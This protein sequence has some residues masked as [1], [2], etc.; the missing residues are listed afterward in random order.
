MVNALKNLR[1]GSQEIAPRSIPGFD[2]IAPMALEPRFMFDAAGAATAADSAEQ[3]QADAEAEQATQQ[4]SDT[5]SSNS[6]SSQSEDAATQPNVPASGSEFDVLRTVDAAQNGG[7]KEVVFIDGSLTG[8][9]DL[10]ADIGD[11]VEIVV[12]DGNADG[13][14]Q[15]VAWAAQNADFDALHIISHGAEGVVYLGNMTLNSETVIARADDLAAIGASLTESGDILLYGCRVAGGDGKAFADAL[16]L[17]TGA[18]IAAS[19]DDTGASNLGG[20]W[21]LE[22]ATGALEGMAYSS[23]YEH[24]LATDN[25]DSATASGTTV[26]SSVDG[27]GYTIAT[28]SG[29][30]WFEF[31]G[32]TV[33]YTSGGSGTVPFIG[34]HFWGQATGDGTSYTFNFNSPVNITSIGMLS[35]ST[36][37]GATYVFSDTTSGSSN[38]NVNVAF[39]SLDGVTMTM[40]GGYHATNVSLGWTAVSS[41]TVTLTGGDGNMRLA[42]DDLIA[43]A[44]PANNA[45]TLTGAPSSV[46]VTEDVSTNIDLSAVTVADSD[47]DTLTVTLEANAGVMTAT[48]SGGVTVSGSGT[49][50]LTLSGSAANINTY[51]DTTTNVSYQ[52][53]SNAN[54]NSAATI[55]AKV[56][57]GT[58]DSSS[59][60]ITVNITAVNDDP[61]ASGVPASIT[62]TE[63]TASNVDLSAITISDV[64]AASSSITVTIAADS[65]TLTASSGGGVTIGGSATG[66]LTLTGT[67]A[68]IDTFLNTASNIQYTGTTNTSGNSAATLTITANDGGNTGT[69]GGGNVTLG[70]VAVNI[71]AVNDDPTAT[72][73]PASIT[74]TEDTA[75]NVD[76]SAITLSDVDAGSSSITVTIAA[77]AGTLAASSG[78]S[79]TVSG[80]STGTLTL[81]GTVA[82]IDTYL[83]TASNIQYTGASNASGNSAATLTITANDGGNTGSGG[84]GNVTLGTVAVNITAVNDDPTGTSMPASVSVTEDTL[85]NVNLSAATFADVDGDTL[86]VT[87]TV[88][89]GTFAT[90]ADGAGVGGGVTETLVNA[91]TITLVG[92]AAD[93]N[94]YLDSSSRI[95]YTPASN[96]TGNNV[97]TITATVN[98]GNGSGDVAAG[99]TQINVTAANDAPVL[100]GLDGA[101]SFTEGG[102]AVVLDSNVTVSDVELAALNGG[103]GNFAGATLVLVQNGGANAADVFSMIT[104][105]NL[106]LNGSN[107]ESGGNV[108]ASFDTSTSGQLTITFQNN[109]TIPTTALVNEVMQ[110]IR[111]S[112][113]SND[114]A[115][116]V[117]IDWTFSDGNSGSAQGTGGALTATGSTTV[118]ITNVNDA[119]TLSATGGNPT[120]VEGAGGSDLFNT[121][122]A[123]TVESADRFSAMTMTVTNVSDGASEI[124]SFDGSDVAL[125]N[126]NSVTSATNGLTVNVSVTGSTA[127]ISFSGATLTSAQMQTLVDGLSYRNTSDNPTTAGNRVVTITSITDNGGTANSGSNSAAPNLTSTV[128]L[129]GVND[130]PV[131]GNLNGDNTAL[132][133]GN[134]SNIDKDGNFT[135]SNADS[136]DYNGGTLVITPNGGNSASGNFS[137][138]GTNVTSGGDGTIAAGETIM[139]GGVA[140]GTVHAT[141]DGQGGNTL[142]ITFNANATDARIQTLVQNTRWS[143]SAGS[144]AQSFDLV[145]NDADG[146]ANGGAESASATF[147]MTLG[148]PAVIANLG[149]D[150]VNYTEGDSAVALDFGGNLTI[151]D[152]DNPA[153]FNSGNL[154]VT[155]SG[156][157]QAGEDILTLITTGNVSL[158]GTTAGSNVSVGGT[159]IGTLGNNIAAGNNLVINFNSNATLARVQD[160]AR[161]VAYQN[162]SQNPTASTRSV[163]MTLTDND[164]LASTA[165]VSSVVVAAVNDAPTLSLANGGTTTISVTEDTAGNFDLS[166]ITISDV[167]NT[168]L[169]VTIAVSG[170]TLTA[171]SSGGVTIGNSGTGSITLQGTVANINTYLDTASNIQYTGAANVNGTAAATYT[172]HAN[173]GTTNPQIGS[174]NIDITAV[175][176][177]PSIGNLSGDSVNY[178]AGQT[179]KLDAGQNALV[180]DIDS[181]NLDLGNGGTLTVSISGGLVAGED[182]LT[183][184]TTGTTITLAGTT[185]GSNVSVGGTVIGTLTN[186]IAAGNSLVISLNSNSTPA[187]VQEVVRAVAYQNTAGTPTYANRTVSFTLSDGDATSSAVTTTI[188]VAKPT[189]TT[190]PPPVTPPA[191]TPPPVVTPPPLLQTPGTATGGDAGTPVS[192]AITTNA[193]GSGS[194]G[195]IIAGGNIQTTVTGQLG[196]TS[197]IG[198]SGTPVS[199]GLSS[200]QVGSGLGGGASIVTGNLGTGG[201]AGGGL[202]GGQG[203]GL[204]GG[205][206]GGVGG[207]GG[208]LGSGLGGGP[209]QGGAGGFGSAAGGSAATGP[210]GGSAGVG[211]GAG[212]AGG[213]TPGGA[214][215]GLG[216]DPNAGGPSDGL[217]GLPLGQPG[218]EPGAEGQDGAQ[219]AEG[220]GAPE[221]EGGDQAAL[222]EGSD[223]LASAWQG[224]FSSQLA[225]FGGMSD[226]EAK[227]LAK[228][229]TLHQMPA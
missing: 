205:T 143:A 86:T 146:T 62:V 189:T 41:F 150:S 6:D 102:S 129:T 187:N 159:V 72:G 105:G 222:E 132:Q 103:N 82:N 104:G 148:N 115:S 89:A 29:G 24:L 98:D 51:L 11:G 120:Y 20:D 139:V 197:P 75:G 2:A 125:T 135:L 91:T 153:S 32:Q 66:T 124:I 202:G 38:S 169:T 158:S 183:I 56:N 166:A 157:A 191:P 186:A 65:G 70:T 173:D 34:G 219:P 53:A 31:S 10:I 61:T 77:S 185:A 84:G 170:G 149:G 216:G 210:T 9:D 179:L 172:I 123:S 85:S 78:G 69:G 55:S 59:S 181:T 118:S 16:A 138:D 110:A 35:V 212:S 224:D 94:T 193:G 223:E 151:T 5:S 131:I 15:I 100:T 39:S 200:S 188:V 192:N 147:T 162:D 33:T 174:G 177:A 152:A 213:L 168:S 81:T 57:D 25:M 79:V 36:E 214:G 45:P 117:Q 109:G 217:D 14:D 99:T 209:A 156:N 22:Y 165:A 52:G 27:I 160:L 87:L 180:T 67:V 137:F 4:E 161:A 18:D 64:D 107:I 176:D 44:A 63:D 74:V 93:I 68:S 101:P 163:S 144:G 126:G 203:G 111:Y 54:G 21:E 190:T 76:L 60:S 95:Q 46:T 225:A 195:P 90:P 204:G 42:F 198:N 211:T 199:A 207:I 48:S 128:S 121:V 218:G 226:Q 220:N 47:G 71:T 141:N 1:T 164:G 114:P 133:P 80:S 208:G 37:T 221:G 30:S 142:T 145:V 50:T 40:G 13:L 23:S 154:T 108:I 92:S 182:L 119:P 113:S 28:S 122:T 227:L 194:A 3:A 43:S 201:A 196:N 26:T 73:V 49:G 96:V 206:A 171:S 127:T 106:T 175:N 228:A 12:L 8:I 229:L 116:S 130:A 19:I 140:I 136:A 7:R 58:V 155:V 88:S 167:D 184:S 178:T 17:A 83:N 134:T 112:N 215:T 97:A